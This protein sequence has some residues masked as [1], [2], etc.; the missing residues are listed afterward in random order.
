MD[1]QTRDE[2]RARCSLATPGPWEYF[3]GGTF[4]M[5]LD[6]PALV[7]CDVLLDAEMRDKLPRGHSQ[8][9]GQFIAHARTDVPALLDDN[10][11]LEGEVERLRELL[12]TC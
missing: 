8:V 1:Q 6:E 9:N 4:V 5:H 2:I 3:E 11:R 7:V 12:S 10:E